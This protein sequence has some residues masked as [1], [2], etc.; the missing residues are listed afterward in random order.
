MEKVLIVTALAGF[1]KSFLEN[2]I[3]TL[4]EMGYEVHCAANENHPGAGNIRRYFEE[5]NVTFHNVGFSSNSPISKETAKAYKEIKTIIGATKYTMI[6]VHTPIAGAVVKLAARKERKRGCK[7]IYTT[8]GFFF[9]KGSGKK[10]WLVYYNV[11][12]MLSRITDMIITINKEDFEAAKTMK[13]K[14]VKYINGVGVDTKRI[15]KTHVDRTEYRKQLQIENEDIMVLSI[16][17]LSERKNHQIIIKALAKLN[18]PKYVYVI[19]GN[20]MNDS[21][22]SEQL[23]SLAKEKKVRLK[24]LG[25]RSDVPQ[26]CKCADIGAFPSAREGLGLAGI[27]LL[28]AG[29]PIVSSNVQ[30]IKDYM[31]EGKTGYMFA[32]Y[33]EEGFAKGIEKLSD[34]STREIMAE[35]CI[36]NA[37]QFDISIS[38]MQMKKI[39]KEI[40]G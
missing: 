38:R 11:E 24:L 6:H 35:Q 18:N 36:E 7:V 1:I 23:I 3:K 28:S 33:N 22:T 4:Q 15:M 12:K 19:C 21:G 32:P 17:E 9:H 40:L 25:L 14:N 39:Y 27:E 2:D 30:G 5:K 8:H 34:K 26:L 10:S 13:C 16:G 20:D 29:I 37:Q 31:A